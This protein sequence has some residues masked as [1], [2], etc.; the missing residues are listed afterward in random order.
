[1]LLAGYSYAYLLNRFVPIHWAP[2]FHGLV[3]VL[4]FAVLPV[5]LRRRPP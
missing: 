4:A 1:M 2:A 5:G 3:L